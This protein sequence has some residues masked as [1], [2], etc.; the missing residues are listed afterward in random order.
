M[1]KV[2]G[3]TLG[4]KKAQLRAAERL[5]QRRIEPTRPLTHELAREIAGL[6]A[7]TRRCF[8]VV[9]DRGGRVKQ[10]AIGDAHR[11]PYP[12]DPTE[13]APARLCGLRFVRT[14]FRDGPLQKPDL[15]LLARHRLD[16]L[17]CV[18]AARDGEPLSIRSAHLLPPSPELGRIR[19]HEPISPTALP[20][21][22][23]ELVDSLEEEFR[24]A[25]DTTRKAGMEERAIVLGIATPH[26][27]R[28]S[29]E[30]MAEMRELARTAGIQ[31]VSHRLQRRETAEPR[32]FL[33]SGV[34]EQIVHEA[35]EVEANVLITDRELTP[36]QTRE[37]EKITGIAVL[38][39][40]ML[41]LKIFERRAR[42]REAKSRVDLARLRTLMP[43]L[44]GRGAR[45]SRQ[46]GG[47]G[48]GKGALRGK[49]E[50]KQET[51]RRAM[52]R[53]I[54]R[55]GRDIERIAV[56]RR[57]GRKRRLR[58]DVPT[59]ALVGY[60]N[61]GKSTLFNALTDGDTQT[62][63]MLF[64]TLDTTTRRAYLPSGQKAL[65]IDT[66]GF[67][68]NLPPQLIDAFR[69]T[70]EEVRNADLL[71]HLVDA[72]NP[73]WPRQVDTVR[74]TLAELEC[75]DIETKLIFNKKDAMDPAFFMPLHR[76]YGGPII[77]ALDRAD[78]GTLIDLLEDWLAGS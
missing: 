71:L 5:Y 19:E 40:T 38:D 20:N 54:D 7:D 37:L 48:G 58:A 46:G 25:V 29:R 6:A 15:N 21:D 77:S 11:V 42:T 63:D 65:M 1:V 26:E 70:L 59:V 35:I 50:Q 45:L 32:T 49:G 24:R 72:S 36:L 55:L 10:V 31:V 3:K 75:A 66:V 2:H 17:A 52:Q 44:I 8:G 67:I 39:R 74:K 9:L 28:T 64:A 22:F 18:H 23:L 73:A 47:G 41:I 43:H 33:G 16:L 53:R 62:E 78:R 76:E 51:D 68:R 12:G 34:L 14:A 60:T 30:T 4:L 69:A 27:A 13:I 56:H 57:E 61:A